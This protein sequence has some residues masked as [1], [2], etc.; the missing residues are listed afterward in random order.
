MDFFAACVRFF[1]F[2]KPM[3]R[4]SLLLI[5]IMG[6]SGC[7][8]HSKNQPPV[9]RYGEEICRQC[10]MSIDDARFASAFI[11]ERGLSQKFDDM[12]CMKTYQQENHLLPARSWV[13]DYSSGA[14]LE[15]SKAFFVVSK[16]QMTPMGYGVAAFSDPLEAKKFSSE[17]QGQLISWEEMEKVLSGAHEWKLKED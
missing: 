12:G 3:R 6:L 5:L 15:V 13:H 17:K 16:S 4:L 11:D 2:Q 14:W 1:L 10:R 8:D 9:I 7:A